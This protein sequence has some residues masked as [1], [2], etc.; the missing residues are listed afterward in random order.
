MQTPSYPD[1]LATAVG[2][3]IDELV[4]GGVKHFCVCPGSRSTPLALTIARHPQAQLWLQLDERSAGFFALGMAKRLHQPVAL[5]CTSG[6]AAANYLPAVVEA[7][8]ARIPL[9]LLT[10]DRPPELR[11]SGAPQTIDQIHLFGSYVRWFVDMALPDPSPT[12]TNYVR[13]VAGRAIAA[14]NGLQPGPVQLN[15][16]FRE[17]LL[18][19][20][21]LAHP[22]GKRA[23]EQPFV[24]SVQGKREL[25]APQ[26]E[27][28]AERLMR[29]ERGLLMVGPQDDPALRPVVRALANR[30]G[31]PLLADHL[32]QTRYGPEKCPSLIDCY[33]AFLRDPA[34]VASYAP[35]LVLRFGA[36][37]TAK[38]FLLYLQ[39]HPD[40][41]QL[42]VDGGAGWLDPTLSA[43]SMIYADPVLLCQQLD[44]VLQAKGY[45][46]RIK[47]AWSQAWQRAQRIT[48]DLI[49]DL[50]MHDP[51]LS[52]PR[53]FAELADL[54]PQDALLYLSN[55]MPVRDA[56][57]FLTNRSRELTV[58]GNRGAN[59]IDGVVS[60]ALGA[61]AV[62]DQPTLLAI[63]DIA[64][65]HDT[66]GLL[67]AKLH[68]IN[69]TIV[70]I[71]NDGGGIF[72][73]LPQASERDHFETVF[74][75]PH[76]LDFAPF[77]QIYGGSY[78]LAEDW[79]SFRSAVESAL[80]TEG[81]SIIE[82]RTDRERNVDQHR[83]LW[84][85][86]SVALAAEGIIAR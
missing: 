12:I 58:Y 48:R 36:M 62:S 31:W 11:D 60:S 6:T 59:G 25:A 19:A 82:V 65:Y 55:S 67:A 79:Q 68:K 63:G 37:P 53:V 72:S 73:F 50:L 17:P 84:P 16:P 20:T 5:V 81:L 18:P 52:E 33:D 71:N 27:A 41:E 70:L 14:S 1:V 2:S 42:I 61:A 26:L 86:V 85:R 45:Q 28:L 75:T 24:S 46:S 30:L 9:I 21:P 8:Q 34:F 51:E 47:G 22:R 38:P 13:T 29:V 57:T 7:S 66:N 43:S 39:Q 69:L 44:E 32:S 35:E 40:C 74:G 78:C 4:L 23:P 15:I 10:A 64:F 56:D 49:E 76:G 77:A 80:Q 3:L 83:V 54:L